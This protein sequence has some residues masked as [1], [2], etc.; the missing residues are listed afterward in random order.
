MRIFWLIACA[1][2]G[3]TFAAPDG[4]PDPGTGPEGDEGDPP[5]G[6]PAASAP[7]CDP[8]DRALRLCVDFEAPVADR[9]PAGAAIAATEVTEMDRDGDPAAALSATSTMHLRE[10]DALDVQGALTLDAW[11]RP[12]GTPT[13]DGFWI[14]DNNQQYGATYTAA[15]TIRCVLGSRAVESRAVVANDGRFHHVACT[16]DRAKLKVFVDGEL[17]RCLDA[18]VEIPITGTSG[19]ALGAN[20]TGADTAPTFYGNFVG[21]LDDVRVWARSDVD[22]CAAAQRTGCRTSC[23]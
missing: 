23:D 7:V 18:T 20:V 15:G 4:E 12:M 5:P 14:L 1:S 16:Y 21:G 6:A 9:S 11:I 17:S 13:P 22:V 10:S 2:A 19:L 8:A 3:C